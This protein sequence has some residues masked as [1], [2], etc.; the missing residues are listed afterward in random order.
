MQEY[1]NSYAA[2]LKKKDF[3]NAAIYRASIYFLQRLQDNLTSITERGLF[4]TDEELLALYFEAYGVF[5]SS[6]N[7][8][9]QQDIKHINILNRKNLDS[10][11]SIKEGRSHIARILMILGDLSKTVLYA[12]VSEVYRVN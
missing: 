10:L 11:N 2:C 1:L 3:Q 6:L 7:I 4:L 12:L 9:L 8:Y 5:Q